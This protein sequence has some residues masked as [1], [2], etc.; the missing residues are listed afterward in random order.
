MAGQ[1]VEILQELEK[2]GNLESVVT[3]QKIRIEKLRTTYESL[4]A[5]HL[6]LQ[7]LI[8]RK[9]RELEDARTEI[10]SIKE[11]SQET[12]QRMRAERDSKIQECEEIRAQVVTPQ[13]MELL[14]V[15]LQKEVE[16]PYKERYEAME[17][18]VDKYRGDFNKLRYDYSFLKSEYEHEQ[19]QH[20]QIVEEMRV[21]HD[22]E[23]MSLKKERDSLMQRM[24]HDSP[25]DTQ[26]TRGLQRENA[27]LHMKIKGLLSELDEIRAQ[28][29]T[30]GLQSDH[31]S[32]LQVRQ[33]AEMTA[34]CKSLETEYDSL[35]LHC[36]TLEAEHE[37]NNQTQEEM[38]I[39]IN[40]LEKETMS[41]K[42]Q[43][44]EMSHKHKVELSNLKM[45]LMKNK[46]DLER[47]RDELKAE[48]DN[49]NN[50][51]QVLERT[52]EHLKKTINEKELELNKRVQSAVEVEWEKITQLEQ[53]KLQLEASIGHL[54]R[55]KLDSDASHRADTE[56]LEEQLRSAIDIKSL[57]EKEC[58]QLKAQLQ[59]AANVA[60]ELNKEKS[61]IQELK[62]KHQQLQN[63][64]QS[65]LSNEQ[66]LLAANERLKTSLELVNDELS[67]LRSDLQRQQ[68][69]S[70]NSL[71]QNR[72]QWQNEKNGLEAQITK[73]EKELKRNEENSKKQEKDNKKKSKKH[74]QTINQLQD[75]IQVLEAKEDQLKLEKDSVK[76]HLELENE[77]LRRQMEKFRKRQNRFKSVLDSGHGA[78]VT[79][80]PASSSPVPF[81]S[82]L[83]QDR[84]QRDI[85][86][87]RD[88]LEELEE[89]QKHISDL[90][91]NT[92][93][94]GDDLR[95][96]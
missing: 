37:R 19:A 64:C 5:Q 87:V 6:Q 65:L 79:F 88:R 16:A 22:M 31:V 58:N 36:Q 38:T 70:N 29:E 21:H 57:A 74:K 47:E 72:Q 60:D 68:D 25:S 94:P 45:S 30:A 63:Q 35:K 15:K 28:R 41:Q 9:E 32:R 77:K 27:Q 44:E 17:N 80:F 85:V 81:N 91:A 73:L 34:K 86:T 20:K 11:Q 46:G 54:E 75:K 52:I 33:L 59:D 43:M 76:K 53:A 61:R 71:E 48:I 1:Q 23:V 8:E 51:V 3:E 78:G 40:R 18:E 82:T 4:K 10:K 42:S 56:K 83:D 14:K 95:I 12:V 26:R 2:M 89:N 7:D 84:Q 69:E 13:R 39:E 96:S 92:E 50:R 90:L 66:Q 55:T 93:R 67:I 62:Q 24:Q 49:Y